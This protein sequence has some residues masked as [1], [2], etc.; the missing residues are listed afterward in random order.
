VADDTRTGSVCDHKRVY[1]DLTQPLSSCAT[2]PARHGA[3][4]KLLVWHDR[5]NINI[6]GK[7]P[8]QTDWWVELVWGIILPELLGFADRSLLSRLP[9]RRIADECQTGSLAT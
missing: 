9:L 4:K 8:T 3:A 5:R 1:Q 2:I 7:S 6:T